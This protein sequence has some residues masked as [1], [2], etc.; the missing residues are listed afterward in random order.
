MCVNGIPNLVAAVLTLQKKRAG[1]VCG[2]IFGGTLMAWI[3][4]Q[5]VIF[6]MNFMS[7]IYF[8]F[9]AA[10]LATGVAA[11][12]F[13]KQ[14]QFQAQ[15]RDYPNIGTDKSRLVVYFSRMGYTRMAA[16]Q[17]AD[18]TGALL[19]E[20]RATERTAGTAG[21]WWCGRFGMHRWDMPIEPVE[22]DLSAFEKVTV[23][24]PIWVFHLSAPV[25]A[26]CKAAAGKI[27]RAD[28][29]LVHFQ[30]ADYS[31]AAVEMDSLLGITAENVTSICTHRGRVISS[32]KI[33]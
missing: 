22:L 30:N 20:I 2:T 6:P 33:R 10:Q 8:I 29:I 25:R 15:C 14:E 12:I 16:Q 4:I 26:F 11:L 17:E 5:F 1:V 24:S 27:A 32:K 21:F 19:Y 31:R 13:L 7:T 23:C 3:C 9:G 28:Y 18:R